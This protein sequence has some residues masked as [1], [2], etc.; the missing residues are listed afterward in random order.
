MTLHR[1]PTT[2]HQPPTTNYN[3]QLRA[4]EEPAPTP[5][6]PHVADQRDAAR[7][8]IAAVAVVLRL[9]FHHVAALEVR[10]GEELP[11][12]VDARVVVELHGHDAAVR[13]ARHES[14][15]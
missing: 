5:L 10:H 11:V 15:E 7:E 2:N 1:Q 4:G 6:P 3:H 14:R 13:V 12:D 9:D 8:E